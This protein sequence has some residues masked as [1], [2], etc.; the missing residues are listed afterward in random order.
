M[1]KQLQCLYLCNIALV[2]TV[3]RQLAI[4]SVVDRSRECH[5]IISEIT[6]R[7]EISGFLRGVV[8]VFDLLGYSRHRLAVGYRSC[9]II[10]SVPFSTPWPFKMGLICCPETSVT[11]HQPRQRS[12][13]E[14]RRHQ[15]LLDLITGMHNTNFCQ[16]NANQRQIL[17]TCTFGGP[18]EWGAAGS[19][20]VLSTPPVINH[21]HNVAKKD[22][23]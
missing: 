20:G 14:G 16:K 9:G 4:G 17:A 13:P 19:A 3:V 15:L 2:R 12:I 6:P 22:W 18:L 21:N 8:D 7:C 5:I 11:N 1:K 23:S 10:L